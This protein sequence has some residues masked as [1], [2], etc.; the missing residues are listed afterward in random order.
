LLE[1]NATILTGGENAGGDVT[2][3]DSLTVS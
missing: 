3:R 2:T 1:R